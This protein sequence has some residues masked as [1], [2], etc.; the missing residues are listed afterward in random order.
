MNFADLYSTNWL[1]PDHQVC[2][3][4]KKPS[5]GAGEREYKFTKFNEA[6]RVSHIRPMVNELNAGSEKIRVPLNIKRERKVPCAINL[7]V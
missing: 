3:S 4:L 7:A 1:L 2:S 6:H 5:G